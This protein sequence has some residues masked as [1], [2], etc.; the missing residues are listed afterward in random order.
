MPDD[1]K[2][3]YHRLECSYPSTPC[4]CSRLQERQRITELL[5]AM[6]EFTVGLAEHKTS[7]KKGRR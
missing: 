2:T 3:T 4:I 6:F 7:R 5:G 1:M